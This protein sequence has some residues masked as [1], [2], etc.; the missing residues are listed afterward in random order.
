M[1]AQST[2]Q[3]TSGLGHSSAKNSF[4]AKPSSGTVRGDGFTLTFNGGWLAVGNLS[5]VLVRA[6]AGSRVNY[7]ITAAYQYPPSKTSPKALIGWDGTAA[8]PTTDVAAKKAPKPSKK[9]PRSAPKPLVSVLA[10]APACAGPVAVTIRDRG[11]FKLSRK[12]A[13]SGSDLFCLLVHAVPSRALALRLSVT[14][15]VVSGKKTH[16]AGHAGPYDLVRRP[17]ISTLHAVH[18]RLSAGAV[19][20]GGE[21]TAYLDAARGA[22]LAYTFDFGHHTV[23]KLAARADSSGYA[24]LRVR[25]NDRIARGKRATV[26]LSVTATQGKRHASVKTRFVIAG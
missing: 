19:R 5:S 7:T 20:A 21:E 12:V 22:S 13:R 10:P 26:T 9:A 16:K 6:A 23:V 24:V 4:K 18:L 11:T 8:P 15:Q 2:V 3:T 1:A 25:L 17:V 14:V